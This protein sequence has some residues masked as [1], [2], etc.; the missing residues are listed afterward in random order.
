[1]TIQD[2]VGN[3]SIVGSNQDSEKNTYK[4]SLNLSLD[5][6]N[7]IKAEWYINNIQ[8]QLGQG[9][10]KDNI[11]V[12]NFQYKGENH[13]TFYGVVVYK[14]LSK[15]VLEGFWSEEYGDPA[16]LGSEQCIRINTQDEFLN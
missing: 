2:L 13:E 3:Y 11:L 10:F 1:M 4:G 14:C 9:F 5:H 8:T 6:H 16:Y 12:I 15:N 7:R